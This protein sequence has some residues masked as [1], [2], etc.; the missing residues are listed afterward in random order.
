[1]SF[2]APSP[3][4][5]L[6]SMQSATS[7]ST[8][9]VFSIEVRV[10]RPRFQMFVKVCD[11]RVAFRCT[12]FTCAACRE[13]EHECEPAEER[14]CGTRHPAELLAR[15]GR[16][17]GQQTLYVEVVG[18]VPVR[19]GSEPSPAIAEDVTELVGDVV[20][21]CHATTVGAE[22]QAD[23]KRSRCFLTAAMRSSPRAATKSPH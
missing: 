5:C 21:G 13:P 10:V 1:M 9:S 15:R 12:P 20:C 8:R 3:K 18:S 19:L 16:D 11:D 6:M 22:I 2:T 17:M 23:R 4:S 14:E 7:C